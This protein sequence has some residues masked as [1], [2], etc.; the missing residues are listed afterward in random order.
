MLRWWDSVGLVAGK[1]KQA[2]DH[3]VN[4]LETIM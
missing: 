3:H 2:E 4:E 1:N